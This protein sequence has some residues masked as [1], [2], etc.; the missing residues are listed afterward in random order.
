[1]AVLTKM[2][3]NLQKYG[4]NVVRFAQNYHES[5]L[6]DEGYTKKYAVKKKQQNNF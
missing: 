5:E 6:G 2:R 1:M 3:S 4:N